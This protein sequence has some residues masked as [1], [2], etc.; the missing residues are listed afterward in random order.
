[1]P[2]TTP[3]VVVPGP[4]GDATPTST[5]APA[6]PPPALSDLPPASAGDVLSVSVDVS[7]CA[8]GVACTVSVEVGLQPSPSRRNVSW[9]V[10]SIDLCS[11]RAVTLASASAV[12]QPGWTHVIGLSQVTLPATSSQVVLAITDSPAQAA[13][14]L[15]AIG[16]THCP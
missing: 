4:P 5:P 14:S 16:S 6:V 1:V 2:V 13:S 7:G 3:I 9:T 8:A 11:G 15:S 10:S 12:A